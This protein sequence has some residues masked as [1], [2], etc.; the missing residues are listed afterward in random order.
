MNPSVEALHISGED[1]TGT[2]TIVT[3]AGEGTGADDSNEAIDQTDVSL[4]GGT[5]RTETGGV[6][7]TRRGIPPSPPTPLKPEGGFA[8]RPEPPEAA[9][10]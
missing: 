1:T 7:V 3:G 9:E 6:S 2:V 8:F 5:G 4:V 10:T